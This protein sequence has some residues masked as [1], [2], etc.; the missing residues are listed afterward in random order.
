MN[1][2]LFKLFQIF[3]V[4]PF[5][6]KNKIVK[7][8]KFLYIWSLLISFTLLILSILRCVHYLNKNTR[9]VNYIFSKLVKYKPF[10]SL[11]GNILSLTPT[12]LSPYKLRKY[13]ENLFKLSRDRPLNKKVIS[14][15]VLVAIESC[16]TLRWMQVVLYPTI[17][18]TRDA[19]TL[20]I[21]MSFRLVHLLHFYLAL[22]GMVEN[23]NEIKRTMKDGEHVFDEFLKVMKVYEQLRALFQTSM[24]FIVV[25]IFYDVLTGVKRIDDYLFYH[26]GVKNDG[27]REAFIVFWCFFLVPLMILVLH[28]GQLFHQKVFYLT[29][30]YK[31]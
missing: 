15:L 3:G 8:S 14:V 31:V 29:K 18:T 1:S 13:I 4:F 23:L 10:W 21:Q 20:P 22:N 19:V 24:R 11:L 30:V 27:D 2:V 5:T 17:E 16:V 25:E 6:T 28:E 12:Y 26:Y 7:L 9:K